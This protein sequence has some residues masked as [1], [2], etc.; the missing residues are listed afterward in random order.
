MYVQKNEKG[1]VVGVFANPQPGIAEEWVEGA[2]T[3]PV[4]PS[5]EQV[6][7]DRLRAYSNPLTGSDRFFAEAT[8][9]EGM[10]DPIKAESARMQG[11]VRYQEI[12]DQNPWP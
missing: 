10:G 11:I 4:L 2:E 12:K 1:D 6:E 5:R 9:L 3:S 8:R 7:A